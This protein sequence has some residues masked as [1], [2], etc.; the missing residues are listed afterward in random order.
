[1]IKNSAQRQV[2]NLKSNIHT[3]VKCMMRTKSMSGCYPPTTKTKTMDQH[4]TLTKHHPVL[5]TSGTK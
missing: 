2:N 3:N 4:E 5:R 1:M